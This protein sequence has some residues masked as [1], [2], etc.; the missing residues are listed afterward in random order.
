VYRVLQTAGTWACGRHKDRSEH[1]GPGADAPTQNTGETSA[2]Q[3]E[4]AGYHLEISDIAPKCGSQI[5]LLQMWTPL[6]LIE[7]DRFEF[8]YI[9]S[10][11]IW[12]DPYILRQV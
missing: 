4:D 5:L 8:Q 12:L 7:C 6:N 2:H 1:P 3:N 11:C 9:W 10:Y